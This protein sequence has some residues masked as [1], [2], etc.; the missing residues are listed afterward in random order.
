MAINNWKSEVSKKRVK[1][2]NRPVSIE[3]VGGL[4]NQMFMF[5]AGVFL[6]KKL[7]SQ[8][9]TVRHKSI[10]LN[11]TPLSELAQFNTQIID[12][13]FDKESSLG[14]QLATK[15]RIA[16]N[17]V[18]RRMGLSSSLA[19][20]VT[21]THIAPGVGEDLGLEAVKP[22]DYVRGYF[23]T[24]IYFEEVKSSILES[25]QL[26]KSTEWFE[27]SLRECRLSHPIMIHIRRGDYLAEENSFIGALSSDYYLNALQHLRE[28]ENLKENE[29]WIFSNDLAM[30]RQEMAHLIQGKV[31][32]MEPPKSSPDGESLVLLGSGEALIMS[33]STFSWWAA[34]LGS[35]RRVVAPKKW[36]R[37]EEDPKTLYLENWERVESCWIQ[38]TPAI[39]TSSKKK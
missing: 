9:R 17:G 16:V 35:P 32:W 36:F 12:E 37:S 38:L 27:K 31:R 33:N 2:R 21:R 22:G 4:G 26:T 6:A 5:T 11:N 28:D 29:I 34:A 10:S 8:L 20:R 15:C 25:F 18:L 14:L 30:V 13:Y 3:L 23:Q 7:G 1:L 19:D 39:N 24:K